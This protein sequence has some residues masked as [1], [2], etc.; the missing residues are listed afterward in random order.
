MSEAES[1]SKRKA[2]EQIEQP[3]IKKANR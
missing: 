1:S 2:E 3:I